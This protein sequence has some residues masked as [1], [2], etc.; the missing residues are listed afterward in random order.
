MRGKNV[1]KKI[2]KDLAE[3]SKKNMASQLISREELFH[4][5]LEYSDDF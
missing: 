5:I 1:F 4:L 2:V 3:P